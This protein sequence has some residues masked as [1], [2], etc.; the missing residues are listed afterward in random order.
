VCGAPVP[1]GMKAISLLF[2]LA[3]FACTGT[4]SDAPAAQTTAPTSAHV[5][6]AGETRPVPS[7][8][9]RVASAE[10]TPLDDG[11][12]LSG[13]QADG[14]NINEACQAAKDDCK[15]NAGCSDVRVEKKCSCWKGGE[16]GMDGGYTCQA[17]CTCP[18]DPNS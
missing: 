18:Q 16:Y 8:R 15:S 11:E 14:R 3:L 13:G 17:K 12:N 6:A 10:Q 2:A 1:P 9:Y 7:L 4:R 5:L